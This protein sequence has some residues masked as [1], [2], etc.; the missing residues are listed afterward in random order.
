MGDEE[1]GLK[2]PRG[3]EGNDKQS[4]KTARAEELEQIPKGAQV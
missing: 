1:T 4:I 2:A 3:L